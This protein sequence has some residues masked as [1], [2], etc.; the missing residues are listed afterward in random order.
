MGP[1]EIKYNQQILKSNAMFIKLFLILIV[2]LEEK[3]FFNLIKK[4]FL[5]FKIFSFLNLMKIRFKN[6]GIK[7]IGR[8]AIFRLIIPNPIK[9]TVEIDKIID[10]DNLL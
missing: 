7:N 5:K 1:K 2:L 3:Y 4:I 6:K 10:V 8:L 9:P